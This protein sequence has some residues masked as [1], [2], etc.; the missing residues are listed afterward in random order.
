MFVVYLHV[1]KSIVLFPLSAHKCT[2]SLYGVATQ[3]SKLIEFI[4]RTVGELSKWLL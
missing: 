1:C 3:V 2:R 4:V